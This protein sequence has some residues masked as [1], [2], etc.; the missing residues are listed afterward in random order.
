[1]RHFH[2][3]QHGCTKVHSNWNHSSVH[4]FIPSIQSNERHK[5]HQLAPWGISTAGNNNKAL[6]ELQ[7]SKGPATQCSNCDPLRYCRAFVGKQN[8]CT[9]TLKHFYMQQYLCC[10][11]PV[12]LNETEMQCASI[13]AQRCVY[14]VYIECDRAHV[15]VSESRLN[16]NLGQ[17]LR[18]WNIQVLVFQRFY[19]SKH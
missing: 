18:G 6:A 12:I 9:Y 4:T 8:Y 10:Y 5:V 2:Q 1:M 7:Q 16:G 13:S 19:C 3:S 14:P 11:F 17:F 15:C